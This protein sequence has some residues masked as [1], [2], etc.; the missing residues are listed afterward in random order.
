MAS[1]TTNPIEPSNQTEILSEDPGR[2]SRRHFLG[3][4]AATGV[5]AVV[6]GQAKSVV[7]PSFT[8]VASA[9]ESAVAS[10]SAVRKL[11]LL[12][13]GSD[14]PWGSLGEFI[15]YNDVELGYYTGASVAD[16]YGDAWADLAGEARAA[17]I[18]ATLRDFYEGKPGGICEEDGPE[19]ERRLRSA[20]LEKLEKMTVEQHDGMTWLEHQ[21]NYK[22][23]G[24]FDPRVAARE[25]IETHIPDSL[26]ERLPIQ[27]WSEVGM[28]FEMSGYLVCGG[29]DSDYVNRE[30][31]AAGIPIVFIGGEDDD[32]WLAAHETG[33]DP[34]GNDSP[35][36][37]Y[38]HPDGDCSEEED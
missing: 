7:L 34:G 3:T 25:L 15:C 17:V 26:R 28:G 20:S 37:E 30:L 22:F 24:L 2:L 21:D 33:R 5:G 14:G 23:A 1:S 36:W 29:E 31:F 13:N 16:V 35:F 11:F 32:R 8:D 38:D 12:S 18:R 9:T 10:E 4:V 19:I 27:P 6:A